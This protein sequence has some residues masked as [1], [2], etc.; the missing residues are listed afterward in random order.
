MANI[1]ISALATTG[2]LLSTNI[3]PIVDTATVSTKT[4]TANVLLNY[5]T[6]TTFNSLT[7]TTLTG[8]TITGSTGLFTR[9][10]G[11]T[12][13]FTNATSSFYASGLGTITAPPYSFT[14]DSNT[15]MWSPTAD[16]IAFSTNGTEGLRI[17][18]NNSVTSSVDFVIANGNLVIGTN[19]KGIDFSVTTPDGTSVTSELL[20]DYEEG[21]W[22]PA[23]TNLGTVTYSSQFSR[24]IKIGKTV[25]AQFNITLNVH[26]GSA[27]AVGIT[28][29]PFTSYNTTA[30]VAHSSLSLD[31]LTSTIVSSELELPA[32][33]T[34]ANLYIRT[35]AAASK[36]VL[37]GT[38]LA[39]GSIFKG[40]L[41]YSVT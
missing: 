29:L 32:G 37:V 41:V 4:V 38:N 31:T 17:S 34:T 8:S 14:G 5:V 30:L 11:S 9:F 28:G 2:T 21:T 27:T 33:G 16:T 10:T 15:G 36:S 3:I 13:L 20:A 24:Y 35:A 22:T 26:T 19:G 40:T 25:S 39:T 23:L 18:P 1:K 6:G 7:V 12:A